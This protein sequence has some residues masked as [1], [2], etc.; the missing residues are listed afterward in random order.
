MVKIIK[1]TDL[2]EKTTYNSD[3]EVVYNYIRNLLDNGEQV[4]V[5]FEDIHALNS[6]FINSAFIE[7]LENYS[8]EHI[9][10]NIKFTNSTK[11]INSLIL[12]RFHDE[13][14]NELLATV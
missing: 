14:N 10:N 8:F 7:L 11:Q 4:I 9:R 5:S 2:V 13:V 3:G 6:S 1:V 12:K